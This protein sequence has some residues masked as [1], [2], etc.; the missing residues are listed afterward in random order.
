MDN[1]NVG[2]LFC[3][4]ENCSLRFVV[5]VLDGLLGVFRLLL[6]GATRVYVYCVFYR[7]KNGQWYYLC[8]NIYLVRKGGLL[9]YSDKRYIEVFLKASVGVLVKVDNS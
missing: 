2:E 7:N 6:L 4:V 1:G 9:K 3:L 8:L 5:S